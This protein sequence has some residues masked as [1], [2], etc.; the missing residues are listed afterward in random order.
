VNSLAVSAVSFLCLVTGA[1]IG[2]ASRSRLPE[3]HLGRESSDVI[4]L[5][6]GLLAT[7]V[8]LVL[9]LLISSANAFYN[10]VDAEYGE[11]LA[12]VR[13]LDDRLKSYGAGAASAR[14]TLRALV[15]DSLRQHWPGERFGTETAAASLP[16]LEREVLALEPRSPAEKWYQAQA[17][18]LLGRLGHLQ[19]LLRNQF[20]SQSVPLPLL[21]VVVLCA[22]AIFTSFG[23][24]VHPNATV[25]AA[26]AVAAL[27]VAA[28]IFL[29]VELN[30]PF[31]GL[32]QL[33]SA[34]A[35]RLLETLGR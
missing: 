23:L 15:V 6:T 21:V 27:A 17:L 24:Y 32:L 11:S 25:L 33:S 18:D 14:H 16:D 12:G 35:H 31:E 2:F 3:H 9:S 30:S 28:A 10:T 1:A 19:S 8:A 5:A 13:Q 22:A 20:R 26:I 29:I 4:K 7:L 34:P